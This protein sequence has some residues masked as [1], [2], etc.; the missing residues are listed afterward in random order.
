MWEILDLELITSGVRLSTPLILAALGG[1]F[2]ERAGVVNIAL[3]GIMI[4]GAFAA[5][6]VAYETG[7]PWLGLIAAVLVGGLIAHVHGVASI[8]YQ[9]DQIVSGT[10]INIL[11]I[12]APAMLAN[13]M[14]GST[15]I[16]P[17]IKLSIPTL[18]IP[19]ISDI[20]VVGMLIGEYSLLIYFAFLMVPF[21]WFILY[22]TS[23]G[24]RLRSVGENPEAADTAGVNVYLMRFYGVWLS[25]I[26]A[27]LG[28]AYLS[29]AHG[30]AY[31]RNISAGRGFIALA[32]LIFGR[33]NPK[34]T[35]VAC[36]MF[37]IADAFQIRVQGVIDIPVQ[38]IQ[39]FP[40]ILTM[41]V[42]AGLIGKSQVP[43]AD[44]VPYTQSK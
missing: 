14:Y 6:S 38:F 11:A 18:S 44:G 5:A 2:S 41:V 10:A 25:G 20:P 39:I 4:F 23:F 21:S 12:G 36:L 22:K 29:I 8:R 1:M 15:S 13:A 35:L 40:Y 16:T 32:A 42:L 43:A 9:A 19:L 24:L 30:S 17:N 28:G 34:L 3:D 37:G 33:Y 31:V 27:G 7:N 26:L